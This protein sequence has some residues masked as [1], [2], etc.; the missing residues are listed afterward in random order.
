MSLPLAVVLGYGLMSLVTFLAYVLDKRAARLGR[1][2]TP[3]NTLHLLE[4][5]GGWPGA[6]VA[7]RTVRHKNAKAAYQVVFWL[8][9]ALHAAAWVAVWRFHF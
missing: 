9:V 4:L 7:Q 2:R 1:P 5:L 6:F 8:I 3:E